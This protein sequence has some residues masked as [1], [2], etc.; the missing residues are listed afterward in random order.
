MSRWWPCGF[1][2]TYKGLNQ[3]SVIIAVNHY[4]ST[5]HVLPENKMWHLV[6]F[7]YLLCNHPSYISPHTHTQQQQHSALL[8]A[9]S[10]KRSDAMQCIQS[11]RNL[12]W[13]VTDVMTL[14]CLPQKFAGCA[15]TPDTLPTTHSQLCMRVTNL[16]IYI[17]NMV[18][19]LWFEGWFP[20]HLC[21]LGKK[22]A[23]KLQK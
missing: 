17:K 14:Q 22:T 7:C 18:H 10:L 1:H 6:L 13:M 9:R 21:S 23:P 15:A 3:S 11:L 5:S 16:H 2:L 8:S 12:T 4:E 19:V 20:R